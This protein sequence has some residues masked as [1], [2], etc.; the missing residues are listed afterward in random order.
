MIPSTVARQYLEPFG[1]CDPLFVASGRLCCGVLVG[2]SPRVDL[3]VMFVRS[4]DVLEH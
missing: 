4:E 3:D 1:A 2:D